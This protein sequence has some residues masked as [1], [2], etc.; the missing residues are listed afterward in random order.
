MAAQSDKYLKKLDV[1]KPNF[2]TLLE[3]QVLVPWNLEDGTLIADTTKWQY[4]KVKLFPFYG[5]KLYHLGGQFSNLF[6][7]KMIAEP[8]HILYENINDNK[9]NND[10]D[11]DIDNVNNNNDKNN[12]SNDG[13][14]Q[15]EQK[16]DEEQ[17]E[18]KLNL[19]NEIKEANVNGVTL[20]NETSKIDDKKDGEITFQSSE[21]IFQASKAR[22]LEDSMFVAKS[23]SPGDS[24][25]AGQGRM[26]QKQLTQ[27]MK[28]YSKMY[29]IYTSELILESEEE[30][31]SK[32]CNDKDKDKDKDKNN[33]DNNYNKKKKKNGKQLG[34]KRKEFVIE[35]EN[36]AWFYWNKNKHEKHSYYRRENWHNIKLQVMYYA[37]QCKFDPIKNSINFNKLL[38]DYIAINIDS[39]VAIFFIEHTKND[40]QWGDGLDGKGKNYLGKLISY[41]CLV[42]K[43]NKNKN[44]YF[45]TR[46]K[47]FQEWINMANIDF[48]KD[49]QS[50]D[51]I[52]SDGQKQNKQKQKQD[53]K[54]IDEWFEANNV[55]KKQ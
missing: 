9:Q 46:N 33:N 6:N 41:L 29:P 21:N 37:L 19:L 8:K 43:F 15:V 47:I 3:A 26:S 14:K 49:I 24:A 32:Q 30:S 5:S 42:Y 52:E 4:Q 16:L 31:D 39:K 13:K 54:A 11:H 22:K 35:N 25:R 1:L 40:N 45:D 53:Y 36:Q 51:C 18:K 28:K 55:Q 2:E 34:K 50:I 23:C 17:E 44:V 48:I 7:C 27:F 10:N 38:K 20:F 12:N